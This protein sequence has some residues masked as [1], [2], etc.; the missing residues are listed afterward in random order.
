MRPEDP[1][2]QHYFAI[3]AL[4]RRG[5]AVAFLESGEG[6]WRKAWASAAGAY[7][8][9]T[10]H[11]IELAGP[12]RTSRP[13]SVV[14]LALVGSPEKSLA[15]LLEFVKAGTITSASD[16]ASP[17]DRGELYVVEAGGNVAETRGAPGD[18]ARVSGAATG[19]LR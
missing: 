5:G 16:Y 3:R 8:Y 7:V 4:R 2:W 18:Q 10:I 19:A 1:Q 9:R 11:V 14:A 6:N 17:S 13:V 15:W 12:I